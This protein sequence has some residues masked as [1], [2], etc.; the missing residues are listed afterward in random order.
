MR[1]GTRTDS[2]ARPIHWIVLLL[3]HKVIQTEIFGIKSANLS[4]GHRFHHPE[5]LSISDPKE[6][7]S[8]L[9]NKGFVIPNFEKRR[10]K[11]MDAIKTIETEK[12]CHVIVD[13]TLLDEV[14]GL[15]EW[16]VVLHGSFDKDFLDIPK[17]VLITSM[18]THQRCFPLTDQQQ[19][20]LPHFLLVSNIQ[21][22]KTEEVIRGNECVISARLSDAVFYYR[23]D[24]EMS[25]EQRSL[26]L[27]NVRFQ[28]K[29]GTLW[30]KSQRISAVAEELASQIHA[31]PLYTKHAALL[32]K[33]DL[34]TQMVGEFPELQSIMGYYYALND[35]EPIAVAKAIADHAHPRFAQD[36]LPTTPEGTALAL[37]DR[38]DSLVGL[39][40]LGYRPTGD[41][42]PFALRRQALG[43]LRILIE[44]QC[45]CDLKDLLVIAKAQYVAQKIAL[46]EIEVV[47]QVLDFCF[48]RLRALYQEQGINPRVF[49]AVFAKRITNP[50]DF[51][52]RIKA[53]NHFI[54]LQEAESLAAANKRVQNILSKCDPTVLT[55]A[56]VN[57]DLLK[58]NAE[59]TLWLQLS[60][61]EQAV[62][63]LLAAGNYTEAL[64][65][66][67]TLREPIDQFFTDVMVMADDLNLRH[68]RL[69]LL[70]RL[71]H[72]FL[73]IADISLL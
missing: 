30:D 21:S 2:F 58:E 62:A 66:L 49:E 34:L 51:D 35:G 48:E 5:P 39:F 72:L 38:L 54:T 60:A 50:L 41:K 14:T 3:D 67:A 9:E 63:P 27:K 22:K 73:E 40:G 26:G 16:P 17:E 15:V 20:L 47:T 13:E 36:A 44:K 71:R 46:S 1:W 10:K 23:V 31:N 25:L 45:D 57:E 33:T 65:S 37:A 55:D 12:K 42:D 8:T 7:E 61:K 52:K 28:Q 69:R 29:L 32:C 11:I 56:T 70:H 6:Y 64:K 53:I 59:K 18:Q 19:K 68:N 43:I 4:Y 24:K